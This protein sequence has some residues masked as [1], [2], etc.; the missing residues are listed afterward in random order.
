MPNE[1]NSEI[2]AKLE[3]LFGARSVSAPASSTH[4]RELEQQLLAAF[5]RRDRERATPKK[6]R[7]LMKNKWFRRS[8]LVSAVAALL[9]AAACVAPAEVDV[10]IGR[11]LSI[12]YDTTRKDAPRPDEIE[13]VL[14]TLI[15]DEA[16]AKQ[17][18]GHDVA[19]YQVTVDLRGDRDNFTT[20][21]AE[22]WGGDSHDEPF[23]PRL[24]KAFVA[25]ADA[26]V[27]EQMRYGRVRESLAK[28]LGHELLDIDF[29]IDHGDVEAARKKVMADLKAHGVDGKVDVQ[30]SDGDGGE[31]RVII[32]VEGEK[33]PAQ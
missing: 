14:S 32:R 1:P 25:L 10:E 13:R 21:N 31:R 3:R 26:D 29:E 28:K 7:P 11:S 9:G 4:A 27:R 5:D 23:G 19:P 2:D 16:N 22:I 8:L 6:E 24:K 15:A 18:A 17:T 30:V 33:T 12:H 20:F